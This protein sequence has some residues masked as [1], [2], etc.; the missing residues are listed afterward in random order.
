MIRADLRMGD[1]A[2]RLLEHQQGVQAETSADIIDKRPRTG[3]DFVYATRSKQELRN[4][5]ELLTEG[6]PSMT[7]TLFS[8]LRLQ[9]RWD[10]HSPNLTV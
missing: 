6:P 10:F 7:E 3:I 9:K 8:R 5:R 1:A 2:V 4:H